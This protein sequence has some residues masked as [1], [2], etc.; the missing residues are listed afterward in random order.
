MAK[1]NIYSTQPLESTKA[2]STATGIGVVAIVLWS[3]LALL[4]KFS[5][6][7]PPFQLLFLSFFIAFLS[8]L[9][10]LFKRGRAS[11]R[12][13]RQS[14]QVWAFKFAAIF[15]YH[16]LYFF[17][18]QSAPPAEASLLA[19]LW[20]L[21]IVIFSIFVERKTFQPKHLV[22]AALGFGGCAVAILGQSVP[23]SGTWNYGGYAAA[24][25]CALVWSGYSVINRRY[26]DVPSEIMGGVCGLVALAALPIHLMTES[27]VFPTISQWISVM[28]LGVGPT[29][30]AF[31][32]WDYATK[33]GRLST[34]GALSY[35]SPLFSTL[36]LIAAGWTAPHW[37]IVVATLLI[38]V[39]AVIATLDRKRF[40][41]GQANRNGV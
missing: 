10:I 3:S 33:H 25:L 12:L 6:N 41:F 8:S 32:A 35:L 5:G 15:F 17:A 24:L 37:A 28:L 7:I 31:F 38:V 36:L 22:G 34:I 1:L 13:W 11:F 18:L 40:P 26:A 4:T 20:P 16:A 2:Q 21:L 27:T 29:G 39:G 19:Y 14:A 9:A 23:L 30:L